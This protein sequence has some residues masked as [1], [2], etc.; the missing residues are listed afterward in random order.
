[1]RSIA[2]SLFFVTTFFAKQY[3]PDYEFSLQQVGKNLERSAMHKKLFSDSRWVWAETFI[4]KKRTNDSLSLS[5][6]TLLWKGPFIKK[7]QAS[8]FTKEPNK[9]LLAIEDFLL[10]DGMWNEKEQKLFF[11]FKH[12]YKLHPLDCFCLVL[13]ID[14]ET[15]GL[16]KKGKFAIDPHSL[17]DQLQ[18][19]L[20]KNISYKIS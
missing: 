7:L 1:M 12:S 19:A 17:P 15:E 20:P 16:L 13:T 8:L 5:G 3:N 18:K 2:I 10:S 9:S 14:E 11:S 4:I 6:L